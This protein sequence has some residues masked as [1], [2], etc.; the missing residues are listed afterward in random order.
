MSLIKIIC[1]LL[2]C[3]FF[4][5]CGSQ[6]QDGPDALTGNW[7][8]LYPDHRLKTYSE[9]EVYGKYQDSLLSLY[10]LKLIALESNGHFR[11]VDSVG[12]GAGKWIYGNDS[13]LKIQEG[14]K[15]FNPFN[16]RFTSLEN[17]TLQVTQYL[18]LEGERIKVVWHLKK[19]D[20]ANSAA[21]LFSTT[22]NDWRRKPSAPETPAAMRKRLASM[23]DYYGEYFLL[24]SKEAIYFSP[25]RVPLP[26]H[27]Y[28]HA[29]GMKQQMNA[30]FKR[31]FFN[32]QDAQQAFILLEQAMTAR[33]IAF[34]RGDNFV[35]EY[36]QF[37]K[38]L[39]DWMNKH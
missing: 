9:R 20:E 28:Q 11:E 36:G 13:L 25:A 14:G 4:L 5:S 39:A 3:S 15:G 8:I 27:Y 33:T 16:A 30:D 12:A 2:L 35:T 6:K 23:L 18:P 31:L 1:I 10:G 38:K 26:F 24:V 29:M 22:A 17:D 34:P 21:S 37:L 32:E 7:L 19:I